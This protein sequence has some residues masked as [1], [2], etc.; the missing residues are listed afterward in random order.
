MANE[1]NFER[2][3]ASLKS[4]NLDITERSIPFQQGMVKIFYIMQLTDRVSLAENIVKPLIL[5]CSSEK[6]PINAQ[7]TV[8]GI[9]YID[10]C[11]IESDTSKI[12]EFILAGMTV[13]LFS[14]D[15][16]YIVV[17][18]KKVEHREVATPQVSYTIRGPQDCFTENL[19]VN[20][21][22]VRYRLKDKSLKI[23]K[24]EVGV[25]TKTR[26]AVIYIDDIANDTVVTE[27]QKRIQSIDVDGIGESG[28]LQA[29]L[30]NK[31]YQIF[32]N[33]GLIERSDMACHTILE[34]KVLVL[35][36]GSG[37]AINA[38]KTFSEFFYSGDDRYDNKFFGLISRILRYI[39]L[40][41][42][43]TSTSLFVALTSFH[44]DVL[45]SK[46]AIALA[47]MRV[48]VPFCALIGAFI[49]EFI[50]ELLREA[51]LR[52][53]NHIGPAI[54]IV[55]A[56]IIG[57]A[58]ISAGIFSPLLLIIASVALLASFVM[59]DYSLIT[60]FRVLK[61]LLLLFT[62]A[63]GFFGFAVF[64]TFILAQLVSENSFGVPYMAPFA[65]FN[66]YDFL[67]TLFY[68]TTTSPKR[69]NYLRTKDNTR[70]KQE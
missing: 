68:N 44:T 63:F 42:A 37:M 55:G 1:Q 39:S 58:S 30:L 10:D 62:G 46:Y 21:S 13:I 35:V 32:P 29:F 28:E 31:K 9:I 41:I 67:R 56:I 34:G 24:Y 53:P 18:L 40:L 66:F 22:L 3:T 65:P 60:P 15:K 14:T 47:E 49:I 20:L 38:P 7:M 70:K 4:K 5:H 51:L 50:T 45:P 17:N 11:K 57:Q 8:D 43:F 2:I 19:D 52:V 64:L 59:P 23:K 54:G 25:R 6:K 48:N 36:D 12:E 16:D 27:I 26:V 69:P 33:M 61:I